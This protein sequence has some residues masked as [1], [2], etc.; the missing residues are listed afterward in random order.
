M[1]SHRSIERALAEAASTLEAFRS[2]SEQMTG[3]DAFVAAALQTIEMDGT[4]Y[5]CGNGGSMSQAMHFA[6]EWTGRFRNTRRA[7]PAL[8]FSDPTELT[9]IANDFGFEEVFARQIEAHGRPGD[10]LILL[11]TSGNS[12]N[13]L[14]AAR[15]A[16]EHDI[17]SIALLGNGGGKLAAEVDIPIVVPIATGS[18][19]IQEIHLHILHS[20][21][22]AVERELFPANYRD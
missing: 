16:K 22:E 13:V 1:T 11:S 20:V 8:A 21:I 10:L 12:E 4:L 3:L 6:E 9:C 15:V 2:E 19:R 17:R 14:R 5:A 7:L 18:D